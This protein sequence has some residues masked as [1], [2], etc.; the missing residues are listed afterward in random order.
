M[1]G[2]IWSRVWYV[3]ILFLSFRVI[4][5]ILI[6]Q[7]IMMTDSGFGKYIIAELKKTNLF[8]QNI[9]GIVNTSD[10]S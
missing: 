9:P 8:P 7:E 1:D 5:G 6:L 4:E 10:S 3:N 2:S